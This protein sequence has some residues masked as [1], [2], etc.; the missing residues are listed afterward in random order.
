MRQ[1]AVRS[2][3]N[4]NPERIRQMVDRIVTERANDGH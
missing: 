2:I 3:K 4:S 1:I